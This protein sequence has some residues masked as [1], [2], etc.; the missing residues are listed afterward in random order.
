M[1]MKQCNHPTWT[2]CIRH[3]SILIPGLDR[4]RRVG[5]ANAISDGFLVVYYSHV[6]VHQDYHRR[7]AGRGLMSRLM[8]RQGT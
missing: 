2:N 7:G 4:E 6:V 5:L 3:R 8:K 1:G